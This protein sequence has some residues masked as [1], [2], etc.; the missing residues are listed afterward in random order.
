MMLDY[1]VK[2]LNQQKLDGKLREFSSEIE[3]A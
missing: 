1:G 2:C 3:L